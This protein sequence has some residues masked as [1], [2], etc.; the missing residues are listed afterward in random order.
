LFDI[1]SNVREEYV[2]I[3]WVLALLGAVGF[4]VLTAVAL[5]RGGLAAGLSTRSSALVSVGAGVVLVGWVAVSAVLAGA[6]VYRQAPGAVVPW[7]GVAAF[8]ALLV[9]LAASRIPVVTRILAAPG[10]TTRLL[11][12]QVLRTVGVVF[13]IAMARGTLPAVF[14]LP[15]GLGDIAIGI[16]AALLIG[17][18]RRGRAI[19]FN[20]LGMVDLTTAIVLGFLAGLSA[21]PVLLVHPSTV[22][23]TQLPLAL[24]PTTAVPLAM[25][26]HVVSLVRLRTAAQD[27]TAPVP[28]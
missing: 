18:L 16:S 9:S 13:L 5:Y 4:P 14:A 2:M 27:L 24:I 3:E 21:N 11:W 26:L 1:R 23:V 17:R 10:T 20:V 19:V 15:A 6:G 8:G 28:A 22:A 12:P 25:A 7:V